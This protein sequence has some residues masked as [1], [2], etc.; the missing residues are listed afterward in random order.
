M[1]SVNINRAGWVLTSVLAVGLLGGLSGC[2]SEPENP[3]VAGSSKAA[4]LSQCV[5]PTD[6]MRRDHMELIKH[7][8]DETVRQGIRKTDHSLH[9]CI[10]CHAQLDKD[11]QPVPVNAPGQFC[12]G[13]HEYTAVQMNC[14]QCHATVPQ[15]DSPAKTAGGLA[16]PNGGLIA[17]QKGAGQ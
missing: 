6:F 12:S 15:G 8:R 4:K 2:S 5:E 11:G 10:D 16:L 7:Q 17:Q 3:A 13:C 1:I 14:F 9:G